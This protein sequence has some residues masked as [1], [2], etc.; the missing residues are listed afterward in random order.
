MSQSGPPRTGPRLQ[1][2]DT[3]PVEG[4]GFEKKR[5]STS[6]LRVGWL[7]FG[8]IFVIPGCVDFTIKNLR[9][10]QPSWGLFQLFEHS[11]VS[12]WRQNSRSVGCSRWEKAEI[13]MGCFALNHA[14]NNRFQ[15]KMCIPLFSFNLL[16]IGSATPASARAPLFWFIFHFSHARQLIGVPVPLLYLLKLSD[17]VCTVA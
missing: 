17:S 14:K 16:W 10:L 5:T 4:H 1:G 11:L 8:A 7:N 6:F 13:D 9:T 3:I 2:G 12:Q 15:Q